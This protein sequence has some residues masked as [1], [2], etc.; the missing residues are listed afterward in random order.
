MIISQLKSVKKAK[1]KSVIDEML[2]ILIEDLQD[3]KKEIEFN[4]S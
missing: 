2:Q 4:K 3:Y 1:S